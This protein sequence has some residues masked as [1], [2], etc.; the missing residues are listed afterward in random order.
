MESHPGESA[1]VFVCSN[2]PNDHVNLL[3]DLI[4]VVEPLA[5]QVA[6]DA[7]EDPKVGRGKVGRVGQ[8]P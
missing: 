5:F 4:D 6:F 2:G 7:L 1:S 8:M 3:D